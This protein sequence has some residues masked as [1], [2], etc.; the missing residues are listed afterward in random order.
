MEDTG[1]YGYAGRILT[2]DLTTGKTRVEQLNVDYAKKYIGGIGLGM[3][4]WVATTTQHADPL[5]TRENA[6]KGSGEVINDKFVSK[7][8][9]CSS[10]PMRCEHEVVIREGPYKGTMTRMEYEMLW[11]MGPYCGI[12]KLDAIIKGVEL[13][14]YYGM[15]ALSAG[16]T[17]GFAMDCHEKGI[18][19]HE[20][21]GVDAH[22]GNADALLTLLEKMGKR[23]G[24]GDI[25]A[26]GG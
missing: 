9:A 16:V 21:L 20:E 1:L 15:D 17:V 10:C 19:S 26:G 25:L 14:N 6:E 18:L 4:L 5:S 7:I 3:R 2:V 23:E 11:A 24:I 22:F 12:D 8:I 13:C